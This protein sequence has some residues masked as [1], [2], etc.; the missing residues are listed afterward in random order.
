M[1]AT[2]QSESTRIA[3]QLR[4]AFEGEAWHGDSLLEILKGVSAGRAAA[5]PIKNGHTIWELVLHIAAWDGA[6]RRRMMGVAVT[7]SDAENFP[8]VTDT[9]EAAW[10][11][12]LAELRRVHEEL[13]AA[14]SA[15]A[16][17]RLYEMVPGKEGAHYTFYYMLH[18]VVQH[19]L[20]HAGQ[21]ALLKKM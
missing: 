9:S 13:I 20:Y 2:T 5:R 14:V 1:A 8:A 6:V 3:D 18:G 21:I 10:A 11:K 4:R 17:S 7:L 12:A 16:D 15:L 19:E